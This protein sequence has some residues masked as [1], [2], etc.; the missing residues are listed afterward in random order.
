M[1]PVY[2]IVLLLFLLLFT[3][4]YKHTYIEMQV[5]L[6]VQTQWHYSGLSNIDFSATASSSGRVVNINAYAHI[7]IPILHE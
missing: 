7:H 4:L 6:A 2:P 1:E 5:K 3:C